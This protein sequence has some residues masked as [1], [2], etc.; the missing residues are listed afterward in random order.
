MARPSEE[1]ER[2]TGLTM[3][4]CMC[5]PPQRASAFEEALEARYAG[6]SWRER[7]R[8]GE[9]ERERA[10]GVSIHRIGCR[11]TYF[12]LAS[13][14]LF[15]RNVLYRFLPA[16]SKYFPALEILP[17][18]FQHCVTRATMPSPSAIQIP[19]TLPSFLLCTLFL[20][21]AQKLLSVE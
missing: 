9:R 19:V 13:G 5:T 17:T 8:D 2:S 11:A 15:L 4:S 16:A 7:W 1:A 18:S 10:Y 20:V 21:I 3:R 12:R 14:N 6:I